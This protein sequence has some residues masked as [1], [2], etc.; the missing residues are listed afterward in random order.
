MKNLTFKE[1]ALYAGATS[2][3]LEGVHMANK[4][5]FAFEIMEETAA[6]RKRLRS[7]IMKL[8]RNGSI[9]ELATITEALADNV[10]AYTIEAI[11]QRFEDGFIGEDLLPKYAKT[12]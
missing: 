2:N 6:V 5:E 1:I 4:G 12:R 8:I 9:N 11:R 3:I 7:Y 10:S